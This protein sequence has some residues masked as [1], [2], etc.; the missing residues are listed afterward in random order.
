MHI[1]AIVAV[2]DKFYRLMFS[3]NILIF[4]LS[5]DTLTPLSTFCTIYDTNVYIMYNTLYFI[6]LYL[7]NYLY[8]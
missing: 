2:F 7:H 5:L 1:L 8:K 3:V 6:E 4:F